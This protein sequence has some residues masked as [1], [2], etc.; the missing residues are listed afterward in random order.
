MTRDKITD[1]NVEVFLTAMADAA[2]A[3]R[4]GGQ[5]WGGE[6]FAARVRGMCPQNAVLN[7]LARAFPA[8]VDLFEQAGPPRETGLGNPEARP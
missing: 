2:D 5:E 8:L 7:N 6:L 1:E 4:I 3:A